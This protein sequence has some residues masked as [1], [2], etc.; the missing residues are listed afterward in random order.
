MEETSAE[1][2]ID[3]WFIESLKIC[4]VSVGAP[5][6]ELQVWKIGG[7]DSESDASDAVSSLQFADANVFVVCA[8]NGDLSFHD[9]RVPSALQRASPGEQ[10]TS[11]W[12]MGLKRGPSTC[13]VVRLSSSGQI[14]MSD[15]RDMS[16]PLHQAQLA[17]RHHAPC[18]DFMNVTLAPA[19]SDHIAVS[20][21]DGT[22]QVYDTTN[23]GPELKDQ[24]PLFVHR[25]HVM[26]SGYDTDTS[27][28]LVT[29]HVWHPWRPRT[30]LSAATDGSLHV[31]DW[32][33]KRADKQ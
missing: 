28:T 16:S 11:T 5:G 33:D 26:S 9:T 22:V 19:L 21:F 25:G 14:I 13:R 7:D 18:C 4:V 3:D 23:W 8:E 27:S 12:C 20:G 10:G 30:V 17:V 24:Q 15:W 32:V 6:S 1:D 29:T 2:G 31:W